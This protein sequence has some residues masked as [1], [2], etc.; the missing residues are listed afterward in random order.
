MYIKEK[1]I[2]DLSRLMQ[3]FQPSDICR[4]TKDGCIQ[5]FVS[6]ARLE[7]FI[8]PF[9]L[10]VLISTKMLGN[11]TLIPHSDLSIAYQLDP[12]AIEFGLFQISKTKPLC[13]YDIFYEGDDEYEKNKHNFHAHVKNMEYE[14]KVLTIEQNRDKISIVN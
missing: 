7:Q 4:T 2:A 14:R 12:I 1:D 3:P 6:K 10:Y 13:W 9:R 5:V 11:F 8:D